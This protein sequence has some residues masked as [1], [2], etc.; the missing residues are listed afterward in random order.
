[1]EEMFSLNIGSKVASIVLA[2]ITNNIIVCDESKT[3]GGD[4]P[5]D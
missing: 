5:K 1:V 3:F 4:V 2:E